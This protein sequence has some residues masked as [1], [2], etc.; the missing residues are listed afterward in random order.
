MLRFGT[1]TVVRVAYE[2]FIQDGRGGGGGAD[3]VIELIDTQG[4]VI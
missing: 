1:Y 4:C 3:G 2:S